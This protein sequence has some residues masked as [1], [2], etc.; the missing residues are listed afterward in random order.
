MESPWRTRWTDRRLDGG[1]Y[2]RPSPIPAIRRRGSGGARGRRAGGNH[3]DAGPAQVP[4]DRAELVAVLERLFD[5][6]NIRFEDD[7]AVWRAVRAYKSAAPESGAGS[8]KGARFADVL[9][10]F[11]AL[12]AAVEGRGT[13]RRLRTMPAE[14]EATKGGKHEEDRLNHN[15]AES[16]NRQAITLSVNQ[17][18][19]NASR[20]SAQPSLGKSRRLN[21]SN[22]LPRAVEG[23]TF[24]VRIPHLGETKSVTV[25]LRRVTRVQS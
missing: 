21:H 24:V 6:P 10:V 14:T 3:V 25:G 11:K 18:D 22:Q 19:A 2:Q 17:S 4:A 15:P 23:V 9:I 7:R 8:G 12:R 5:E 1:R 13:G 20:L 16:G